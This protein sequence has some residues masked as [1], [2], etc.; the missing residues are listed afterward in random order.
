MSSNT[1]Y[2]FKTRLNAVFYAFFF[3][4]L[5]VFCCCFLRFFVSCVQWWLLI[6]CQWHLGVNWVL[7]WSVF[8]FRCFVIALWKCQSKDNQN[9]YLIYWTQNLEKMY[10]YFVWEK[11]NTQWFDWKTDIDHDSRFCLVL[12]LSKHQ[13]NGKICFQTKSEDKSLI[14]L[15]R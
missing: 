6:R 12:I 1:S 15:N 11:L 2:I 5:L 8:V 13:M 3:V 14:K 9:I 10:V 4:C 7:F